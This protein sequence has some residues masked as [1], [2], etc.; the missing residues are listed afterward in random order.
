MLPEIRPAKEMRMAGVTV[1]AVKE[2]LLE[3]G[4]EAE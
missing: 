4:F 3:K 1:K 2:A